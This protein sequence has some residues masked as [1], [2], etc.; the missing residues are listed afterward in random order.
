MNAL[1]PKYWM[2]MQ[3]KYGNSDVPLVDDVSEVNT[4]QAAE[5][6]KYQPTTLAIWRSTGKGPTYICRGRHRK[7]RLCH[8]WKFDQEQAVIIDP[9]DKVEY[10][11]D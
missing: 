6:L 10:L 2:D 1:I 5:I 3:H 11:L 7:Y 4:K 8:L 9:N